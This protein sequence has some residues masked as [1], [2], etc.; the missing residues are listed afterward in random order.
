MAEAARFDPR[1]CGGGAGCSG[2]E[3]EAVA[4]AGEW[5]WDAEVGGASVWECACR[6]CGDT[7]V[8]ASWAGEG[9]AGND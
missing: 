4:A 1:C 6:S 3:A 5:T 2:G 7:D 9:S 8:G